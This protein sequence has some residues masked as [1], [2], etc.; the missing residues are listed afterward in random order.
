MTCVI[1]D[2]GERKPGTTTVT[3]SG[4]ATTLVVRGV[5]A[6]ICDNCGEE[7]IDEKTARWLDHEAE[8]AA[9]ERVEVEIRNY[10]A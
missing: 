3:L 7:Y 1:C 9:R 8:R 5:P 4:E 2:N 6:D 10:A